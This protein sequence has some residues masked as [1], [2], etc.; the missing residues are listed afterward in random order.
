MSRADGRSAL[1]EPILVQHRL[2]HGEQVG[3][4]RPDRLGWLTRIMRRNTSWSR[5]G[6]SATAYFSRDSRNCLT[7]LSCRAAIEATKALFSKRV[8][9]SKDRARGAPEWNGPA[10]GRI[11]G[12]RPGHFGPDR[13]FGRLAG[14]PGHG[15]PQE[16]FDLRVHAAQLGTR[17]ALYLRP[18]PRIHPQQERLFPGSPRAVRYRAFRR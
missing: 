5:S 10:A 6:T 3:L 1:P 4:G 7:A 8:H 17:Q 9:C 2:G 12:C 11:C 18:E 15:F 13:G 16:V 14:V